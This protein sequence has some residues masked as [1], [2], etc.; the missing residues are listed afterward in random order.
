MCKNGVLAKETEADIAEHV[1]SK[2]HHEL[3]TLNVFFLN[4][5]LNIYHNDFTVFFKPVI[6]ILRNKTVV[7]NN[8]VRKML[9][10]AF[11]SI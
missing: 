10:I 4:Q 1:F 3:K 8:T 2:G 6:E 9:K 11:P 7:N 5:H